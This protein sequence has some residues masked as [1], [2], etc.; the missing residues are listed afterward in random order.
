MSLE[1]YEIKIKELLGKIE[2]PL[3]QKNL[4]E[5]GMFSSLEQIDEKFHLLLKT[6]NPDRKIQ[7]EI[8]ARIRKSFANVPSF[9]GKVKIK[10]EIDE[11][12]KEKEAVNRRLPEVGKIIAIASGKGGVGKST[13]AANLAVSLVQEGK[14]VGLLDAD[15]YG[16]SLGSMFGVSGKLELSGDGKNS[17]YPHIAHGVKM[18]SFS[19]LLG[20]S[21][22]VVWRG[23]MLG[24]AIEQFLFQVVW[25]ELDY[26]IFD[27][28]PGTGDVQL[29]MA[30][31]IQVDGGVIVTTPQNVALQDARRA[32]QMFLNLKVPILGVIEN[33][34]HF[35][36]P[37]CGTSSHIFSK[38]GGKTLASDINVPFLG[39][40]PLQEEI[41]ESGEKGLPFVL[42]QKSSPTAKVCREIC[43]LIASASQ[44]SQE[45]QRSS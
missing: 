16:P 41:M 18:V 3:Y 42:D 1:K 17:I 26:L 19:F 34:S 21:Q 15:I 4:M 36:C 20:K 31:L 32:S 6:S 2:H 33:M 24:K 28:P 38:N 29:S 35:V 25:G 11:S 22:A 40:I 5:L 8:E 27:L 30:Q 43:Q 23:P 9:V 12:L 44:K 37:S 45:A 10:F 39:S 7:I 13:V 14:K